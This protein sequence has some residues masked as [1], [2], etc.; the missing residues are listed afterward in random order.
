VILLARLI[1]GAL[2]SPGVP[3]GRAITPDSFKTA[4]WNRLKWKSSAVISATTAC[5]L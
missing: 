4:F 3:Q 1:S 5:P 2:N